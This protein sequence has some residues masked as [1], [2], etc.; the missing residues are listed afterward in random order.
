M[1]I[2]AEVHWKFKNLGRGTVRE[3]YFNVYVG[4]VSPI[5]LRSRR[6]FDTEALAEK[7]AERAILRIHRET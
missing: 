5:V 1:S 2:R 6:Y 4:R 7:A 3:Y